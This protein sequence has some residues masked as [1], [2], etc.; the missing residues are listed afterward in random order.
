MSITKF[1]KETSIVINFLILSWPPF[2]RP[3]VFNMAHVTTETVPEAQG[4]IRH[5][6]LPQTSIS[7]QLGY[8][9]QNLLGTDNSP[10]MSFA[11]SSSSSPSRSRASTIGAADQSE[12][13]MPT[14]QS[15]DLPSREEYSLHSSYRDPGMG[16]RKRLTSEPRYIEEYAAGCIHSPHSNGNINAQRESTATPPSESGR[17]LT[18]LTN[19]SSGRRYVNTTTIALD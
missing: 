6:L 17:V 14:F 15:V 3:D 4:T 19:N 18:P 9:S 2:F 12:N 16:Q 11:R 13:S 8:S 1:Q 10:N 5:A 7:T